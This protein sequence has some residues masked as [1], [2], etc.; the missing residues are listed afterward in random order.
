MREIDGK[1]HVLIYTCQLTTID[2][3]DMGSLATPDYAIGREWERNTIAALKSEGWV[4]KS[5]WYCE[6][7]DESNWPHQSEDEEE[8]FESNRPHQS[9]DEEEDFESYKWRIANL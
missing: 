3:Y 8:D 2:G 1:G 9:E 4:C 5:K 6:W 7:K